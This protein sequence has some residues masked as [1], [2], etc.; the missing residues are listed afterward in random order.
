MTSAVIDAGGLG[1][2]GSRQP[3]RAPFTVRQLLTPVFYYRRRALFAFLIPVLIALIVALLAHP[4]FVAQSRL[5]ILLGDDYVFQT[6][7]AQT[8]IQ[9]FDRSQIVHAEMEILGSRD[10]R[11]RTLNMV[12]LDKVYP[13]LAGRPDGMALG[14]IKLDKDLTVDNIPQSNVIE[15]ALRNRSSQVAADVLNK[16]VGLYIER[17]REIFQQSDLASVSDQRD[18]LNGQLSEAEKAITDFSTAHGFGDYTQEFTAVQTQATA[19]ATQLQSTDEQI[20]AREARAAQLRSRAASTPGVTQL[21]IDTGRSQQIETLTTT[22]LTLQQQRRETANKYT[23]GYPLVADLDH[24]IAEVQAE[25]ARAPQE[26]F[27]ASRR[28]VNPVHQ[29]LDTEVA[30]AEGDAAGLRAGRGEIQRSLQAVTARLNDLTA[31]GPQYRTLVK[32]RDLSEEA[33]TS[34]SKRAEDSELS[35]MLSKSHANVRVIQSADP[36]AKGHSGRLVIVGAGVV[37]GLFAA[38]A[39]VI[40]SLAFSEVMVSPSDVEQKLDLPIILAVPDIKRE[41][42]RSALR[43]THLTPEDSHLLMR[44]LAS[45]PSDGGRVLQFVSAHEG[46]GVSSLLLDIG[47]IEGAG[48][49]RVLYIDVDPRP[50]HEVVSE[51][52]KQGVGLARQPG[53]RVVQVAG[54]SLYVTQPVSGADLASGQ[55]DWRKVLTKARGAYDLILIDPPPLQ[56][57]AAALALAPFADITLAVIEAERTRAA[58]ARNLVDRVESA[59]GEVLGVILNKR[60]FY[61]P[62][63]IY[64]WL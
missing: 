53:E 5:L 43:P 17:R 1:A 38:L 64:S 63:M 39:V 62:R 32:T 11:L 29:Q 18:R 13:D 7:N 8:P 54:T 35:D 21:S 33:S 4:I 25:I 52:S 36:P 41:G 48:D 61:I 44:L 59:G 55:T 2:A 57:S 45:V 47:L 22:L 51:F 10:L 27:S 28:G 12:G 15:L 46:E 37:A 3:L 16:L 20:A 31:L 14:E 34:L 60:R 30:D 24:R 9:T 58:V 23:D 50:G 42:R 26:Q 40:L 19:L 49:R 56:R 6:G